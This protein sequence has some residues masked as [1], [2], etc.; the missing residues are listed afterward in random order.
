MGIDLHGEGSVLLQRI[1]RAIHIEWA[2]GT[3]GGSCSVCI[4]QLLIQIGVLLPNLQTIRS[5]SRIGSGVVGFHGGVQI[6]RCLIDLGLALLGTACLLDLRCS[7]DG[8]L[9]SSP[10]LI[11][12]L[13]VLDC[14]GGLQGRIQIAL[15]KLV[16]AQAEIALAQVLVVDRERNVLMKGSLG[17]RV[18]NPHEQLAQFRNVQTSSH[19]ARHPCGLGFGKVVFGRILHHCRLFRG[20]EPDVQVV[21]AVFGEA[22]VGHGEQTFRRHV[23]FRGVAAIH[24]VPF[25][26]FKLVGIDGLLLVEL[27][28]RSLQ[29]R[30]RSVELFLC[31][32]VGGIRIKNLLS[33][34]NGV[35]QR[36]PFL[37]GMITLLQRLGR[38]DF[39]VQRSIVH[40]R[41][42]CRNAPNRL[43]QNHIQVLSEL[44]VRL[45]RRTVDDVRLL[46]AR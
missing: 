36:I 41:A 45:K 32:P 35:L 29:V 40:L 1:R 23:A 27:I 17:I 16:I 42:L 24:A 10:S 15:I 43:V 34:S 21:G 8:I 19:G 20:K 3:D 37:V 38:L 22:V 26:H 14:L 7:C 4:D 2:F 11:A 25:T 30:Y 46:L 9:Q 39:I 28:D 44:R 6:G 13:A 12:L 5:G 31:V 33:S 18:G